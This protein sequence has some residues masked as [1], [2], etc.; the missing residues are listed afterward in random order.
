MFRGKDSNESKTDKKLRIMQE[1][2]NQLEAVIMKQAEER[3]ARINIILES[4]ETLRENVKAL[5]DS[6]E[7]EFHAF[8]IC[9]DKMYSGEPG[10]TKV[11]F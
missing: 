3:R 2:L 6:G 8:Q 11:Y 7:N 1:N 4:N 10:Q 5:I 9:Y